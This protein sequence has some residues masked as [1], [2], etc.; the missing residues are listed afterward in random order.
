MSL[1]TFQNLFLQ[2]K[3]LLLPPVIVGPA[4]IHIKKSFA[5]Y[6]FFAATLIGQCRELEGVQALGTDSEKAL[7]DAFKNSLD[8]LSI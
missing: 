3:H 8:L 2:T 5:T 6:L 4:C 7:L 1:I